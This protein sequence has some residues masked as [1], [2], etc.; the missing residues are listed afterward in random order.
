MRGSELLADRKKVFDYL[1]I[2][3]E[4]EMR[5][6]V[7]DFRKGGEVLLAVCR[8]YDVIEAKLGQLLQTEEDTQKKVDKLEEEAGIDLPELKRIVESL[9]VGERKADI[10]KSELVEANLRLVVSIAKKYT[11]YFSHRMNGNHR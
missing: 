2:K 1:V 6:I 3:E 9:Q 7:R 10:A 5:E 8:K 4:K 11:P